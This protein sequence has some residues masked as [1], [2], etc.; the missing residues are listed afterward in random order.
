MQWCQTNSTSAE[1][2][3][4]EATEKNKRRRY[5][6][7]QAFTYMP[8]DAAEARKRSR[9]L[10]GGKRLK[11]GI[12]IPIDETTPDGDSTDEDTSQTNGHL[13]IQAT[14]LM[15]PQSLPTLSSQA[16][17]YIT[18]AMRHSYFSTSKTYPSR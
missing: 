15:N 12:T 1:R 2:K 13:E 6:Y 11:S 18:H 3:S 17:R 14:I 5:A 10:Y 9:V 16:F 4:Q 8:I 7:R